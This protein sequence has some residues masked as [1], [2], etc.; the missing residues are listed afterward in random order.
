MTL[1]TPPFSNNQ[2][3]QAGFTLVELAI[4]LVIIGLIVGGVLV[5]QDLIKSAETRATIS[6]IEKFNAA[7]TTFRDKFGGLPGDLNNSRASQFGLGPTRASGTGQGDGNGLIEGAGASTPEGLMGETVMFWSDLTT[8]SLISSS[9][10]APATNGTAGVADDLPSSRMREAAKFH[11]YS[12]LGRNYFYIGGFG[13]AVN[14]STG[15][16]TASNAISPIQAF[17]IDEKLDN[18]DGDEGVVIAIDT[19]AAN[20][21]ATDNMGSAGECFS[22]ADGTY[23]TDGTDG[24]AI[25]CKLSIRAA[26]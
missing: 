13:S 11:V 5:G 17:S 25:A 26:F 19:L 15:A 23:N 7:A 2:Q 1:K 18:G 21:E 8:A 4:V 20:A 14:S 16:F 6:Q 12:V 10:S 3:S 24:D 22:N 9:V